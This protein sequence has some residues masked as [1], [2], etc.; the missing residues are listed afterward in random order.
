MS[1]FQV[2]LSE[3]DK[4]NEIAEIKPQSEPVFGGYQAPKRRSK[5]ARI[6]KIFGISLLAF[7]LLF[8]LGGY[9]FLRSYKPTPQY[10]LALLVDA[11]RR[12]DQAAIDELINTDAIVEDFMPQI[13]D[14]AVELYGR[15]LTPAVIKKIAQVTAPLIP[16]VKQRARDEVPSL[17][18][19]KTKPFESVPFWGIVL[20]ASRYLEISEEGDKAVVKSKLPDRPLEITMKRNGDR[21]KVVGLK[22]EVLARKVAEKIGQE[23]IEKAKKIGTK[24]TGEQIGL[25]NLDDIL[26]SNEIFK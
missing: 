13:T 11:A 10:S 22:D 15:G 25:D 12:E 2:N 23:L 19:E 7:L 21:W 5:S 17:V 9:L 14:K 6:L 8:A 4:G 20:G 26:N 3:P 16:A 18:R 24:K 1:R